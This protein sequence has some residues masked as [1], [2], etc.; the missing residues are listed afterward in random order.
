MKTQDDSFQRLTSGDATDIAFASYLTAKDEELKP[1]VEKLRLRQ[2]TVK[3]SD[4]THR[5]INHWTE[6][7]ILDDTRE[8]DGKGWRKLS[9]IDLIWIQIL[10]SLRRFGMPLK[11]LMKAHDTT[12]FVLGQKDKPW[13]MLE[14]QIVQCLHE[15]PVSLIVFDDGWCE[16]VSKQDY[17]F[18]LVIGMLNEQ[19]YIVVNL[20]HCVSHVIP[21][22]DR[23]NFQITIPLSSAELN[24]I[25]KLR[26]GKLSELHIKL[27][28][29][30][31][32]NLQEIHKGTEN[33]IKSMIEKIKHGEYR[34]K[35]QDGRTVFIETS[36]NE[37]FDS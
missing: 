31:V 4:A 6:I 18:N 1:I 29:G 5:L 14:F 25:E 34:V 21:K 9:I 11:A 19:A 24:V 30:K 10:K 3:D 15:R 7:G 27:K 32:H 20:N 26:A 12:Y 8:G 16:Y 35:I 2:F 13:P 28:D 36:L 23:P 37:R 22:V 17:D 33:D